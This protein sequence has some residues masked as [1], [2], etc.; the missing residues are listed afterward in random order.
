M[1]RQPEA[2]TLAALA[3]I[4][5]IMVLGNSMIIPVLPQ[6]KSALN[7]TQFQVSL[8]ISL[9]SIPAGVIIPL[10]GFLSDRFGRKK[11]IISGLTLYGMGGII[12]G[13]SASLIKQDAFYW[14]I[15]GRIIQGLGAAGT[16][17]IAMALAGDLFTSKKRSKALGIIEAANGFGKVLSPIIGAAAGLISWFAPFLLFPL[18]A[19]PA[20]IGILILVREPRSLNRETLKHYFTSIGQV[21]Q[22]KASLLFASFAAGMTALL[23]LFGVLFF[24]SNF[25]ETNFGW[26]GIL[27][28]AVLTVPVLFM[29]LASYVTGLVVKKKFVLMKWLVVSGLILIA[30]SLAA[31]GVFQTTSLFFIAISIA[32]TG[33]GLVLPCLNTIITSTVDAEKRGLI[34]SLYGSVRFFGVAAGPPVFGLFMD[35]GMTAAFWIAAGMA[36]AIALTST[37]LIEVKSSAVK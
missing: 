18:M 1:S 30:A 7:L 24:L 26:Q 27:K 32:G 14:I 34:T 8:I 31:L 10:A 6:I 19:L 13:L 23:I 37:L 11:V 9:F 33:T 16:A 22:K 2:V 12:A 35:A 29:C 15:G 36:G 28:G 17:P 4:P 20:I 21:F 25:L 3:C 5:F